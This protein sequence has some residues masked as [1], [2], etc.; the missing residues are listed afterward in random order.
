MRSAVELAHRLFAEQR[1]RIHA[2][3]NRDPLKRPEP[4]IA[5]AALE[6]AH[7]RAMDQQHLCECFLAPTASRAIGP[8]VL[9]DCS[10]QLALHQGK[11][12]GP[13]LDGLQ[14]YR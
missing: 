4:Q 2:E 13:L 9:P 6:L 3:P 1:D 8:Q 10:L 14:T 11:A 12:R 7:A 5:F